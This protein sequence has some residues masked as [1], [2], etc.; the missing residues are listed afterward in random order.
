MAGLGYVRR[1]Q[2][3]WER[4][5]NAQIGLPGGHGHQKRTSQLHLPGTAPFLGKFFC[6]VGLDFF[7]ALI[8]F[9]VSVTFIASNLQNPF[10]VEAIYKHA[11]T[12][13][14]IIRD[15]LAGIG[16]LIKNAEDTPLDGVLLADS[17]ITPKNKIKLYFEI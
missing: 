13:N 4:T 14:F 16:R 12:A 17:D 7:L 10:Q 1:D 8:F 3:R 2:S 5:D 9:N 6:F 11:W 15:V